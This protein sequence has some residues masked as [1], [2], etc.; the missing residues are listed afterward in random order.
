MVNIPRAKARGVP[1]TVS[2][3]AMKQSAEAATQTSQALAKVG[4]D[5]AKLG[6]QMQNLNDL[7]D[8]TKAKTQASKAML[9][10]KMAAERD[11]TPWDMSARYTSQLQAAVDSAASHIRNP[12]MLDQFKQSAGLQMLK[13]SHAITVMERKAQLAEAKATMT[14]AVEVLHDRYYDAKTP[15]ERTAIEN[16]TRGLVGAFVN[17]GGVYGEAAKEMV[18]DT[19]EAMRITAIDYDLDKHLEATIEE[20]MLGEDG[21]Y[22]DV[23]ASVR[24]E[25]LKD[26]ETMLRHRQSV[27]ILVNKINKDKVDATLIDAYRKGELSPAM[28]DDALLKGLENKPG[29]GN[30]RVINALKKLQL[31]QVNIKRTI[32][33]KSR[34]LEELDEAFTTMFLTKVPG[35]KGGGYKATRDTNLENMSRWRELVLLRKAEGY[36]T[37]GEA[38]TRFAKIERIYGGEIT[39]AVYERLNQEKNMW[40][41]IESVTTPFMEVGPV[42]QVAKQLFPV[43]R[44]P[45]ISQR[46]MDQGIMDLRAQLELRLSLIDLMRPLSLDERQSIVNDIKT[47]YIH[48]LFPDLVGSEIPNGVYTMQNGLTI[49][50]DIES[51]KDAAE[52]EAILSVDEAGVWTETK[53]TGE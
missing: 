40:T 37:D 27:A 20:L 44:P 49:L 4:G 10:I 3:T 39:D 15:N 43:V 42:G 1:L 16:E 36:L 17:Q 22:K 2:P 51:G 53:P 6:Q 48:A 41:A 52:I 38:K 9:D 24:E 30:S 35:D 18:D 28:L 50:S 12:A 8:L 5:V 7:R 13:D 11:Q 34:V 14:Q 26:G 47:G 45:A 46:A 29:G 23:L 33:E 31:A 21:K 25:K 19:I 32:S